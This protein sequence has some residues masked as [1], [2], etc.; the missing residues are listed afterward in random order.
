MPQA[1]VSGHE[2]ERRSARLA[3]PT[4]PAGAIGSMAAE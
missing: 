1:V 4:T 2:I 3:N